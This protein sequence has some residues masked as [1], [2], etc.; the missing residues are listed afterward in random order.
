MTTTNEKQQ[1]Q[2]KKLAYAYRHRIAKSTRDFMRVALIGALF[3]VDAFTIQLMTG[4]PVPDVPI[5][6]LLLLAIL[7]IGSITGTFIMN[8]ALVNQK[9]AFHDTP[10]N[11]LFNVLGEALWFTLYYAA[12][13]A[14]LLKRIDI[15]MLRC[16]TQTFASFVQVFADRL[17]KSVSL[18]ILDISGASITRCLHLTDNWKP[19]SVMIVYHLLVS[20][21]ILPFLVAAARRTISSDETLTAS[22]SDQPP[23]QRPDEKSTWRD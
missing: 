4:F 12:F 11:L 10:W 15:S 17:L 3:Y 14:L 9:L 18:D 5:W 22:N 1:A 13:T 2:K 8:Y 20:L 6:V 7:L 19:V 23:E 16:E 21:L